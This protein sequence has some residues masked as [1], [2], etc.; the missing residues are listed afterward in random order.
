VPQAPLCLE[1]ALILHE[2]EAK[3]N[4]SSSGK[5]ALPSHF[6]ALNRAGEERLDSLGSDSDWSGWND[7]GQSSH[8][9]AVGKKS[10]VEP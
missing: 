5:E 9:V 7:G 1:T 8:P 3:A 4:Y 6:V 2:G 10:V